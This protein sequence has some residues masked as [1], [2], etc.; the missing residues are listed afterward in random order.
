[1]RLVS[2]LYCALP[3]FE[4]STAASNSFV[5]KHPELLIRQ[6]SHPNPGFSRDHVFPIHLLHDWILRIPHAGSPLKEI[7]YSREELIYAIKKYLKIVVLTSREDRRTFARSMPPGWNYG[8]CPYA[9]HHELHEA[10]PGEEATIATELRCED[11][12]C[13]GC[14]R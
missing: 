4:S 7:E 14:A 8:E 13:E 6:V 5:E 3:G 9:R 1:M 2:D 11:A 10:A 12:N